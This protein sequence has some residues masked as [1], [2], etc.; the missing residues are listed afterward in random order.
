MK[1]NF[2]V[3]RS[4]SQNI[5]MWVSKKQTKK[6]KQKNQHE[7]L[8]RFTIVSVLSLSCFPLSP[9]RNWLRTHEFIQYEKER[10]YGVR[11]AIRFHVR[12][13]TLIIYSALGPCIYADQFM[14]ERSGIKFTPND[15]P[16]LT[17]PEETNGAPRWCFNIA[18]Y[19]GVPGKGTDVALRMRTGWG[20]GQGHHTPRLGSDKL[21]WL[22]VFACPAAIKRETLD[23]DWRAMDRALFRWGPE[24]RVRAG[25]WRSTTL[26]CLG[27]G[28]GLAARS[29]LCGRALAKI[30]ITLTRKETEK[31][32]PDKNPTLTMELVIQLTRIR[33]KFLRAQIL[34]TFRSST[35]WLLTKGWALCWHAQA[36]TSSFLLASIQFHHAKRFI[37]SL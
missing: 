4:F 3:E 15:S 17:S 37:L 36:K 8:V 27:Y 25:A 24:A 20:A 11:A 19:L 23:R 10:V 28:V 1:R 2:D 16:S 5:L 13:Y 33:L 21:G 29:G 34:P 31:S 32:T 7:Q 9:G 18:N 12:H 6:T 35:S 14:A 22:G 26:I 30:T